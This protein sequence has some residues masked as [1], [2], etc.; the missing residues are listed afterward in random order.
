MNFLRRIFPATASDRGAQSFPDV[1]KYKSDE[2]YK[3]FDQHLNEL[4]TICCNWLHNDDDL[5]KFEKDINI[6]LIKLRH[7]I[8]SYSYDSEKQKRKMEAI[9]E[10]EQEIDQVR[11]IGKLCYYSIGCDKELLDLIREKIPDQTLQLTA[12]AELLMLLPSETREVTGGYRGM[13]RQ[14]L[15]DHL[16]ENFE[17]ADHFDQNILPLGKTFPRTINPWPSKRELGPGVYERI[18][19]PERKK[20]FSSGEFKWHR[21][22]RSETES[23]NPDL[24]RHEL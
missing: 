12:Y 24:T 3:T 1:P 7:T 23:R 6:L 22:I 4:K 14:Y 15:L 18:W 5:W 13:T 16:P 11:L 2:P 17:I 9:S 19:S 8:Q 21:L 20:I 10:I